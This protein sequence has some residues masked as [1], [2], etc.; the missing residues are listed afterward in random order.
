ML[1]RS[2]DS[3]KI[4]WFDYESVWKA[5]G[6]FAEELLSRFDEVE[7]II[8]FGSLAR[9]E[10]VPGSDVD[11]LIILRESHLP[12]PDR[13]PIFMPREPF[14]VAVDGFPYTADE[15]E[16]MLREGNWFIKRALEEGIV[17]RERR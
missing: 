1:R 13:I 3:V 8:V 5:V 10:S 2:S 12:F 16:R 17:V 14:P 4:S 7:R 9:G 11:L 6:R 15:I